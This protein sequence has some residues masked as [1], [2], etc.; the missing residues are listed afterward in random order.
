MSMYVL[1]PS[2]KLGWEMYDIH[3]EFGYVYKFGTN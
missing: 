1:E 3:C 2:R